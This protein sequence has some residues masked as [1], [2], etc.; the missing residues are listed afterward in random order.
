MQNSAR[1]ACSGRSSPSPRNTTCTTPLASRRSM[2]T[3]PPWSRRRATQP[4]RVT[5]SPA[6]ASAQRSRPVGSNHRV[7]SLFRHSPRPCGPGPGRPPRSAA[8]APGVSPVRNGFVARSAPMVV[9]GPCPGSTCVSSGSGQAHPGQ[10]VQDGRVVTAGQVGAADRAREQQITGEQHLL[11]GLARNVT[12]PGVCPGAW[13]TTSSTPGQPQRHPVGQLDHVVGLGERQP[14]E[15]L[16]PNRQREALGG[17]GEQRPGRPGGCRRGCPG[18]RTP[19]PPTRCGRRGRG[20]P[21]P[22]PAAAGARRGVR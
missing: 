6:W 5:R 7:I 10:A 22:P 13:S 2:K 14:T 17:V 4:A 15:Q 18:R 12:E 16:L 11:A 8:T 3:T 9:C 19:A 21:A 20:S 1:S